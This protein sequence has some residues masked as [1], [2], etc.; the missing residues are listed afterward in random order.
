M[1][2][3]RHLLPRLSASCPSLATR[4]LSTTRPQQWAM[5]SK[6]NTKSE[7]ISVTLP[8]SAFNMFQTDEKPSLDVE[9]TKE[10]LLDMYTKM[11]TMRRLEMAA[12]GLYKS[13]KI[14]GFC[15]LCTGQEAVSVGMEAAISHQDNIITAYRCHGFTYVR[16]GSLMSVL[17]E[18]MG[19]RDGIS[20]GKGGS[21]HMFSPSFYGGHGIVGAQ[22]CLC[23]HIAFI[24]LTC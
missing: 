22:V 23:Y 15:H 3:T 20:K 13:K 8:D 12:D 17:A 19:H 11:T 21:M 4:T 7:K 18:L 16:G 1:L 10:E 24:T 9:I 2:A 6:G 14:R 5:P